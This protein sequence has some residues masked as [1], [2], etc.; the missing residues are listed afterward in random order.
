MSSEPLDLQAASW[1][2]R[3]VCPPGH[4]CVNVATVVGD[5]TMADQDQPV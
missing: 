2:E 5:V 3:H 1:S 4:R